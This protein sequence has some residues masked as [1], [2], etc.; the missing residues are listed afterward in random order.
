MKKVFPLLEPP[1]HGSK[2][3]HK[4]ISQFYNELNEDLDKL[5]DEILNSVKSSVESEIIPMMIKDIE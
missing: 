2:T 3:T 4:K 1:Q 5:K